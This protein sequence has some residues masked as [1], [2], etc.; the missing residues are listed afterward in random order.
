MTGKA[1]VTQE[2]S[3]GPQCF[4]YETC[5][6]SGSLPE[7]DSLPFL[8][9]HCR[10]KN[11]HRRIE[12]RVKGRREKWNTADTKIYSGVCL[13]NK[14]TSLS[15]RQWGHWAADQGAGKAGVFSP[16]GSCSTHWVDDALQGLKAVI[17]RKHVILTVRNP[18][19][20][21]TQQTQTHTETCKVR[22]WRT[23]KSHWVQGAPS[24]VEP[25]GTEGLA[26]AQ[27]PH[28]KALSHNELTSRPS[29]AGP[30][31][32]LQLLRLF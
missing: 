27:G 25:A 9:F 23:G 10:V 6:K 24:H 15:E 8:V 11:W 5:L 12:T 17:Y 22:T 2:H 19:Q 26:W 31:S 28:C 29:G 3:N 18:G 7:Q 20:L 16:R 30:E 1:E 4:Q 21:R 14:T 13:K 32:R